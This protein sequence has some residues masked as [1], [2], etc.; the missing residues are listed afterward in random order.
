M[1]NERVLKNDIDQVGRLYTVSG[2]QDIFKDN[3]IVH[4][5]EFLE[6]WKP[7]FGIRNA[8]GINRTNPTKLAM[9]PP[10]LN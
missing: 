4:F 10:I 1:G 2:G 5:H 8:G 9:S 7:Q 6:L 3:F